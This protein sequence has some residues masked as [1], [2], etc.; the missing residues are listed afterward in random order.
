MRKAITASLSVFYSLVFASH[1][2]LA[3]FTNTTKVKETADLP[4]AEVLN[5]ILRYANLGIALVFILFSLLM[6]ASGI[7]FLM[8]GGDEGSLDKAHGMWRIAAVGM[9]SALIGYI[10]VNLINFFI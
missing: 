3:E 2:A 7:E 8:A 4:T 1:K 5:Q 9:V 6:L 10:I